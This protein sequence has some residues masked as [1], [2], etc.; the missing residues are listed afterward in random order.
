MRAPSSLIVGL[1]LCLAGCDDHYRVRT[2]TG[3]DAQAGKRLIDQ[4]QCGACHA[5]PGIPAATGRAGPPLADF[6]KRSYIAGSIPNTQQTLTRWLIDPPAMK[7]GT[8][9]PALGL[10]EDDARNMAAYLYQPDE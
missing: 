9:M 7:P 10:S 5:I 1:F 4:Y 2:V 6:G 8:L 3:G